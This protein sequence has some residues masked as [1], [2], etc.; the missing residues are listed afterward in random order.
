MIMAWQGKQAVTRNKSWF[1]CLEGSDPGMT[2]EMT[3]DSDVRTDQVRENVDA[4]DSELNVPELPR[5]VDL[6]D[7]APSALPGT[8]PVWDE[9]SSGPS[10]GRGRL[11]GLRPN[12]ALS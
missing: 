11:A 9:A 12:S 1:Q 7:S 10:R 8:I 5:E 6:G 4:W 3:C 2:V